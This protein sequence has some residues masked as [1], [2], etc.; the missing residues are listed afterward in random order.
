MVYIQCGVASYHLVTKETPPVWHNN[1]Q[2]SKVPTGFCV[3]PFNKRNFLLG[4][5]GLGGKSNDAW[6][7]K[8][9]PLSK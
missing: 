9:N 5:R 4:T 2:P 3:A 7:H 8:G 1:V 6:A